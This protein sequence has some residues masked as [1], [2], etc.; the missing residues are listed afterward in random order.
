[1]CV[2]GRREYLEALVVRGH[3]D[4]HAGTRFRHVVRGGSPVDVPKGECEEREAKEC[5]DFEDEQR[6]GHP[7]DVEGERPAGSP[8]QVAK[9]VREREEG[10]RADGPGSPSRL[11]DG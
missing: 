4:R 3:E 2:G 11:G 8:D 1:M 7:P 5:V 9:G 6:E 10:D